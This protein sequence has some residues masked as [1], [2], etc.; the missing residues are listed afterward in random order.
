MRI[1]RMDFLHGYF[2]IL[3]SLELHQIPISLEFV[4]GIIECE[5]FRMLKALI[6]NKQP[7][8]S[9]FNYN[10]HFIPNIQPR[11]PNIMSPMEFVK[12]CSQFVVGTN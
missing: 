11:H 8:H 10:G 9:H 12:S 5:V 1:V 6:P 4:D 2:S 3:K 7:G